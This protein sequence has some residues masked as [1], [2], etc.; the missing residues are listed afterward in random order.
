[1]AQTPGT[2]RPAPADA[3]T[4]GRLRRALDDWVELAHAVRTTALRGQPPPAETLDDWLQRVRANTDAI[5][6]AIVWL[7]RAPAPSAHVAPRPRSEQLL[8]HLIE[9]RIV[10]LKAHLVAA[11]SAEADVA[12]QRARRR[13]AKRLAPAARRRLQTTW[14][15][16]QALGTLLLPGIV[17][18]VPSV[19]RQ[20]LLWV[21]AHV[22]PVSA[23]VIE[24]QRTPK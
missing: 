7:W 8:D 3:V 11:S 1:V 22:L 17:W 12:V 23:P 24:V 6:E 10:T 20:D 19:T 14:A 9:S 4:L 16:A 5:S 15:A 13:R 18:A 2:G 21:L